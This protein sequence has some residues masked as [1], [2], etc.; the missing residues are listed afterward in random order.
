MKYV[1]KLSKFFL[2]IFYRV[3]EDMI[4]SEITTS[5]NKKR[6]RSSIV[7]ILKKKTSKYAEKCSLKIPLSGYDVNIFKDVIQFA[8]C[9]SV[10]INVKNVLGKS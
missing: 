7:S 1:D 4:L 10:G 2:Y 5:A 3:F 6:G 9:G 8:H